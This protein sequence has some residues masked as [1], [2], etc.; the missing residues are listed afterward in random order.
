M[1]A[2]A[3]SWGKSRRKRRGRVGRLKGDVAAEEE[4]GFWNDHLIFCGTLIQFT[5]L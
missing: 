4:N 5:S 2:A 3:R 1:V